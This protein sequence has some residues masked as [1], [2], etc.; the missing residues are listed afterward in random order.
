MRRLALFVFILLL[1]C[2]PAAWAGN[3]ALVLSEDGGPYSE[4]A[5]A[6]RDALDGSEWHIVRA[7]RP[8]SAPPDLIVAVG[9]E[10]L[11]KVLA[12][13]PT[14]PV[15]ATL[16]PRQSYERILAD[17]GRPRSRLTAITLDQPPARQ[18]S[19][20]RHLLPGHKRVGLL[21]SDETQ[22]QAP[23][24]RQ[25]FANA[26]LSVDSEASDG[27]S[28]TL[29]SALNSL[30]PRVNLLLALPDSTIY[31]RDNVKAI[32]VTAYRHQRPL[33]AYSAAFVKAGALAALY[34]TPAQIARQTADLLLAASPPPAGAIAPAL[35]AVS[36]NQNVA[37]AL[38]LAIP[39]EVT[40][41][42]A[43]LADRESR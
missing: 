6:L 29:L 2:V 34:S 10:A 7:G 43:I 11:R 21:L 16:L 26:G 27:D 28:S 18:A 38:G 14:V 4:F 3:L 41:R 42:Q 24:F 12:G 36:I 19:F 13:H 35:F 9:S 37:Q 1:A 39:D 17:S 33:I 23:A 31:K 20:L 30:L 32:L 15:L 25:A 40:I 5:T 8:G 22:A